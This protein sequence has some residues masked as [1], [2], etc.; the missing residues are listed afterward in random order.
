MLQVNINTHEL[1]KGVNLTVSASEKK[2]TLPILS[3]FLL[4]ARD[5]SL[6]ITASDLETTIRGIIPAEVLSP[7]KLT[8][9]SKA[10]S[11]IVRSINSE[12]VSLKEGDQLTLEFKANQFRTV[13][14]GLSAES[15]PKLL[16]EED[17]VFKE[18]D[19]KA[20]T[21]AIDKVIFSVAAR[22]DRYNLAGIYMVLEEIDE[23]K[24]LRLVS[25]DSKRLNIA[26]VS[27]EIED[28]E[29]ERGIIMSK[30]G[31]QEL[32]RLAETST[33][34]QLGVSFSSVMAKTETSLLEIHLLEGGFPDYRLV[35]PKN[36]ERHAKVNRL[37]FLET[38]KRVALISDDQSR[39]GKFEFSQDS[40]HISVV[41]SAVGQ[42]E[43][44]L[45]I[46]YDGES[47]STGFNLT[48]YIEVL[49]SLRSDEI[50][51]S[52]RDPKLAFLVT[53][54]ADLG[55]FGIIMTSTV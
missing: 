18:I 33:S 10:F 4:E 24:S 36:Y 6:I 39:I 21:D 43:E 9:P 3:H 32:R 7:G 28:F 13:F 45:T 29:L 30:K 34:I 20:L 5:N 42:A 44:T 40:L 23:R 55:Y 12:T 25:S 48:Y 8:V 31:V 53:G 37:T 27:R 49:N 14:F 17:F 52:F 15:F 51:I 50:T 46:E 19:S 26:T 41:N 35:V 16:N 47:M 1:V 54:T 11:S 22:D 2:S 38:L